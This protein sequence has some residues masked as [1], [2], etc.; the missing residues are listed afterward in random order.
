VEW[1]TAGMRDTAER[2][3]RLAGEVWRRRCAVT[4]A[5]QELGRWHPAH[6]DLDATAA[7][8][9]E[10]A[11]G[12]ERRAAALERADGMMHLDVDLGWLAVDLWIDLDAV[13][14][15]PSGGSSGTAAVLERW[16]HDPAALAAAA[17]FLDTHPSGALARAL[18]ASLGPAGVAALP[19]VVA[20][21]FPDD[22]AAARGILASISAA[23]GRATR[24]G[25]LGFDPA[26]L[27]AAWRDDQLRYHPAELLRFGQFSEAFVVEMAV[28]VL[29]PY[30]FLS[31]PLPLP[32]APTF[33]PPGSPGN[34]DP[35]LLVLDSAAAD[36]ACSVALLNR[37]A[38]R[39]TLASLLFP[40]TGYDD[41]GTAAGRILAQ[42]GTA[43]DPA[44][45]WAGTEVE[46]AADRA[47][48]AV[49]GTVS[50]H[51]PTLP[52]MV[53]VGAA[54]MI[55]TNLPALVPSG[56]AWDGAAYRRRLVGT[57]PRA[58][59]DLPDNPGVRLDEAE[60]RRFLESVL[61]SDT[62][63]TALLDIVST[64][65]ATEVT[66]RT[67]AEQAAV[68]DD[69]GALVGRITEI[70]A[71]IQ[72]E[73]GA[74]A[75]SAHALMRTLLTGAIAVFAVAAPASAPVWVS[76]LAQTAGGPA[77]EWAVDQILND[78]NEKDALTAAADRGD[79]FERDLWLVLSVAGI[80][81]TEPA[82]FGATP[83][84][85]D[86][87]GRL[88]LP[89]P[90]ADPDEPAEVRTRRLWAEWVDQLPMERLR[91]LEQLAGLALGQMSQANELEDAVQ[92][93]R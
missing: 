35:R 14:R 92:E 90:G 58:L 3:R 17:H 57:V 44:G 88:L 12:L 22:P 73:Q 55:R 46:A 15:T 63:T 71:Q 67:A 62:A 43:A 66:G 53:G 30:G 40:A 16:R 74:A 45:A 21:A 19:S 89:D 78:D 75:D 50:A 83:P 52:G 32:T 10:E 59:H 2:L 24:H 8:A 37:L 82:W 60:V 84:P 54:A 77:A 34:V 36:T 9:D 13:R 70:R 33:G 26:D 76:L 93:G 42:V 51:E 20:S 69:I 79:G 56:Y 6:R 5:M 4:S 64:W 11:T 29:E 25:D 68:L 65:I 31:M 23:L 72:I 61:A 91:E 7:W 39:D 85:I 41:E 27:V 28:E 80:W 87:A 81:N 1:D 86:G 18:F 49:V 48:A 47:I 38:D